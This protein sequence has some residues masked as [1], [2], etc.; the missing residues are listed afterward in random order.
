MYADRVLQTST[1]TGTGAATL[2]VSVDKYHDW[3]D[4]FVDGQRVRYAIVNK[5]KATPEWEY[6]EGV[7]VAGTPD[8]ITRVRVL[9][10]S[11]GT[12]DL[13]DFTAGEK[14]VYCGPGSDSV[15]TP[16]RAYFQGG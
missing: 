2:E 11:A 10:N 9:K 4:W 8:Q 5:D 15:P 6:G 1:F 13:I 14:E 7:F 16:G 12:R 3:S